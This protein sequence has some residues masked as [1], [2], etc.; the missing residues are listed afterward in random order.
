M[1]D[2]GPTLPEQSRTRRVWWSPAALVALIAA[3]LLIVGPWTPLASFG[4]A[5]G[6]AYAAPANPNHVGVVV[7]NGIPGKAVEF[8]CVGWGSGMTAK[9]ALVAAYK[10]AKFGADGRACF[11]DNY[12]SGGCQ[13]PP[14]ANAGYWAFATSDGKGSWVQQDKTVSQDLKIG[15]ATVVGWKYIADGGAQQTPAIMPKIETICPPGST[16]TPTPS[17]TPS[18]SP[19]PSHTPTTGSTTGA[20]GSGSNPGTDYTQP[21]YQT[22]TGQPTLPSYPGGGYPGAPGAVDAGNAGTATPGGT[23]IG[24]KLPDNRAA[25]YDTRDW[26]RWGL[27]LVAAGFALVIVTMGL[28]GTNVYLSRKAAPKGRHRRS[29]RRTTFAV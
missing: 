23:G 25:A 11:I 14:P 21:S 2:A 1:A 6:C 5:S 22:P 9:D 10:D 28:F 8:R 20:P 19:T 3:A 15:N 16:V 27:I 24:G 26:T 4:F 7:D 18:K 17:K 12:P 29:E 13:S